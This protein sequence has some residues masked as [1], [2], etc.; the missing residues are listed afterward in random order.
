MDALQSIDLGGEMLLVSLDYDLRN[1]IQ[2]NKKEYS[3]LIVK[4]M[5]RSKFK[6]F[7]NDYFLELFF[8]LFRTFFRTATPIDISSI[9]L[10]FCVNSSCILSIA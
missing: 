8:F 10:L 3:I 4:K 5:E 2:G 6:T 1:I 7:L 9:V